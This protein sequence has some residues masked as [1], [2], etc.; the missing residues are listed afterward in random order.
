MVNLSK[1]AEK[2]INTTGR[3]QNIAKR[4]KIKIFDW[5]NDLLLIS[6]AQ[7]LKGCLN[8]LQTFHLSNTK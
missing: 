1:I 5:L 3:M 8:A 2:E 4:I 7:G 6:K